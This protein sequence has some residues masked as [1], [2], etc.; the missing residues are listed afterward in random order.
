MSARAFYTTPTIADS[1]ITSA[2]IADGTIVN[3]DINGS[4]AIAQSKI[5]NLTSDLAAKVTT[6]TLI[7]PRTTSTA[8]STTP[9]P[10][11][12]TTDVY[13]LT[14]LAAGATFGAPTGTPVEAQNLLIRIL[15]NGTARALAWNAAYRAVG[16]TLPTTTVISKVLYVGCRWNSTASKWDVLAVAQEA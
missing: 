12:D 6:G 15:D 8:S 10:N 13:I 2:K 9:T 4:A 11:A 3:A 5:A 16:V 14:A 1:S 7:P